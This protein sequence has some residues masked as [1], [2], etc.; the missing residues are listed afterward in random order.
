MSSNIISKFPQANITVIEST[1]ELLLETL[2]RSKLTIGLG[3]I[4]LYISY[5]LGIKTISYVSNSGINPS[6]PLPKELIL[7]DLKEIED[8][9]F[10]EIKHIGMSSENFEE[11]I[12]DL[13]RQI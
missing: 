10:K 4:V 13:K 5:I 6:L 11:L 2:S 3:S 8:I 9:S 7:K 12:K 1:D